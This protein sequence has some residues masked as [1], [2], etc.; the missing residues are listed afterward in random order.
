MR[1]V[2]DGSASSNK[3]RGHHRSRST[4]TARTKSIFHTID[5]I[6]SIPYIKPGVRPSSNRRATHIA[7]T[8]V[9]HETAAW[10]ASLPATIRRKH[11]TPEE[12]ILF[13]NEGQ[14]IILDAAD[15]LLQ[16]QKPAHDSDLF[17]VSHPHTS[18]SPEVSPRHSIDNISDSEQV[19]EK[20]KMNSQQYL[21]SLNWLDSNNDLDLRLDDYHAAVQETAKRQAA[22]PPV[23]SFRNTYRRNMSLS[24]VSLRRTSISSPLKSA[25][26]TP[27]MYFNRLQTPTTPQ[28]PSFHHA[29]KS[30]MSAV[31]ARATHYQ[32]PAARMK[33]RVY[34]ASPDKFDEALH[35]GYAK[36]PDRP[37][38]SPGLP[39]E[40]KRS[41]DID[42]VP[43][44]AADDASTH[45]EIDALSDPRTP[46]ESEFRSLQSKKSSV[47]RVP[48]KPQV[49]RTDQ[50]AHSTTLDRDMTIHMTLTRP[51]L[52][53]PDDARPS[54]RHINAQPLEQAPLPP[55][56]TGQPSIWDSLPP[57]PT[58]SKVRKLWRRMK[59]L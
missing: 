41:I 56:E 53:S 17:W 46:S 29:P 36:V 49:I 47:D 11:F 59:L 37:K 50:Y 5:S 12:Q 8:L 33:L 14:H 57:A 10:F 30:S 28:R 51:D 31:D 23:P 48:M 44:L 19:Q 40:S 20:D 9:N 15:E 26:R 39:H 18:Q 1:L 22:P 42:D 13:A 35:F 34:L 27:S 16:K 54:S 2:H 24:T 52:R 43:S 4:F 6:P 45:S 21:E 55:L 32:D 58:E 38:T 7:E 25:S 3:Q